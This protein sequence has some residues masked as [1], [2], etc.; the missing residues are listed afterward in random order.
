VIRAALA[1][2]P[3]F[4]AHI[5]IKANKRANVVPL[6]SKLTSHKS[7]ITPAPTLNDGPAKI[8]DR[9]LTIAIVAKVLADPPTILKMRDRGIVT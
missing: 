2:G 9:G 7:F 3:E 1:I 5:F 4:V 6:F 8:P